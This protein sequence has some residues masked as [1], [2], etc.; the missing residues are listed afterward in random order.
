LYENTVGYNGENGIELDVCNNNILN[1]NHTNY[2]K[3]QHGI[4][5]D[6]SNNN[7][8]FNNESYN[9]AGNGVRLQVRS[10][11]AQGSIGNQII[12]NSALSNTSGCNAYIENASGNII[13]G[14]DWGASL[15][16]LD[17]RE[18][19]SDFPRDR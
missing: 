13:S 7:Y 1:K 18:P 4:T 6:A 8:I 3:I 12:G 9:N 5:L 11:Q 19:A 16:R 10:D 2:Q 14:N 15:A 17:S